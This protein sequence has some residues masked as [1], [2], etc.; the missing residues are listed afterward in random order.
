MSLST[1][2]RLDVTLSPSTPALLLGAIARG[3]HQAWAGPADEALEELFGWSLFAG[4][5][6]LAAV[7]PEDL[8]AHLARPDTGLRV[9]SPSG[10]WRLVTLS[11]C[12]TRRLQIDALLAAIGPW[13]LA[14]DGAEIGEVSP[15]TDIDERQDS[16]RALIR[17]TGGVATVSPLE[18]HVRDQEDSLL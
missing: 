16:R 6:A 11:A 10:A 17:W 5:S 7:W 12:P 13:V 2:I 8:A 4:E 18:R 3:L 14:E 9:Q 15:E 1:L